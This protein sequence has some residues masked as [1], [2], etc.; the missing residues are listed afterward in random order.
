MPGVRL[1]ARPRRSLTSMITSTAHP[2]VKRVKALARKRVRD[3]E[4]AFFAEGIAVTIEAVETKAPLETV[5]VAPALL[6]SESGQAAVATARSA[7]V[8][9]TE[10]SDDV[11]DAM[12]SRDAPT[13][14]AVVARTAYV[15][16]DELAATSG[17]LIVGLQEPGDPGNLG[18]I[19]RTAD[20]CSCAAVILGGPATD[21][22]SPQA[23]RASMGAVFRIDVARTPGLDEAIAW[24]RTRGLG[25][26]ATSAHAH[27]RLWDARLPKG[28]LYLFGNEQKGLTQELRSGADIEVSLP[29]EGGAS[30]LNLAVAAGVVLFEANR[31]RLGQ[32]AS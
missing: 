29:M 22:Y 1:P 5:I 30:S 10:V 27:T 23:V 21:P 25:V 13:G 8:E 15:E 17:S 14:L 18:T 19:L 28:A 9:I 4:K 3:E 31:R 2:L 20:A 32:T 11:F 26:V 7:G 24:S 6:S 16:L 12:S